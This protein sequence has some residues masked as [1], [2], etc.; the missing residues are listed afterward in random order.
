[1]RVAPLRDAAAGLLEALRARCGRLGVPPEADRLRT[2]IAAD[3]LVAAVAGSQGTV[4]R[5]AAL[6]DASIPTTAQA[7]GTS[8]SSAS[9]LRTA[10]TDDRW[11]LLDGVLQQAENGVARA[12]PIATEL[13]A[14]FERDE[15]S[16]KLA[17]A[18]AKAY[19]AAVE[20]VMPNPKPPVGTQRETFSLAAARTKLDELEQSGVTQV[21]M[22]WTPPS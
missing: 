9:A 10:L 19:A 17:P 11:S 14:A 21:T 3:T 22:E 15:F 13:R 20:L 18:V 12:Q 6:A 4:E 1:V 8:L 2:A 5:I 7:L 16:E